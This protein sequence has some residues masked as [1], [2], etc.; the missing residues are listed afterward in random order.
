M[1]GGGGGHGALVGDEAVQPPTPPEWVVEPSP[2]D[3]MWIGHPCHLVNGLSHLRVVVSFEVI[4]SPLQIVL[5]W[6]DHPKSSRRWLWLSYP[7]KWA[8]RWLGH[9]KAHPL[10]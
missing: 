10:E 8:L 9:T 6:L 1:N 3:F 7:T 5:R 4:E 2:C